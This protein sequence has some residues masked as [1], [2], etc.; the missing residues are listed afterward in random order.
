VSTV[1]L[2]PFDPSHLVGV[3]ELCEAERWPSL[4]SDPARAGTM[5]SAPSAT[6][7][8]AVDGAAVVG[9]A[10]AIVDAGRLD[11][12]LS[13]MVVQGEYRRRGIA[14]FLIAEVFRLS[15]AERIDLLAE[16]GSEA[17]Y[18]SLPHRRFAGFR[19][20]PGSSENRVGTSGSTDGG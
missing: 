10:Y 3:L 20:Y 19:L 18:E 15:G 12:Y 17:F 14:R 5:L 8:V 7:V 4:P 9:V 2:L 13:I 1:A 16:P 11:A 6:T